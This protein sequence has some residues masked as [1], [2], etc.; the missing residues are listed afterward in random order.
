MTS[1]P[2][3]LQYLAMVQGRGGQLS[4]QEQYLQQVAGRQP[5]RG[6]MRLA[7]GSPLQALRQ[8]VSPGSTMGQIGGREGQ[9][10]R[11][12]EEQTGGVGPAMEP[13]DMV[14]ALG[15]QTGRPTSNTAQ[16]DQLLRILMARGMSRGQALQ[17]IQQ[18][19]VGR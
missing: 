9:M 10:N 1:I 11:A 3:I 13:Q 8:M 7:G 14:G 18:A 6:E 15:G 2:S 5:D 16:L 17:A 19:G 12:I 4:P